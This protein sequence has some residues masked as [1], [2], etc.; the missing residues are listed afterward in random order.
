MGGGGGGHGHLQPL[1]VAGPVETVR[2]FMSTMW[3]VFFS[4]LVNSNKIHAHEVE[5]IQLENSERFHVKELEN[6]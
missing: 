4:F 5:K 2:N 6:W 3:K 1:G